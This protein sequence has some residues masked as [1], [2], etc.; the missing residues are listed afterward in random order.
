MPDFGSPVAAN[1]NVDPNKGLT[2]LSNLM[3]LQQQKQQIQSGA[4]T[5]QRQQAELPG[6]QAQTQG[7]VQAMQERQLLQKSMMAGKDPDGNPLKTPEGDYDPVALTAFA[8]KYLPLTGQQVVQHTVKTLD[9]RIRLNDA[10]RGVGQNYANDI[11]GKI[12]SFIG[13]NATPKDIGDAIDTYVQQ[14]PNGGQPLAIAAA[15]AKSL[16]QNLG[17]QVP[18]QQR[19]N[20]LLHLAQAFQPAGATA[21]QQAPAVEGVTNEQGRRAYVQTNPQAP[22]GTGP[23]LNAQGKP[24]TVGQGLAP[25]IILD[26]NGQPHYVGGSAQGPNGATGTTPWATRPGV[27]AQ[28]GAAADMSKH[29]EN[30]NLASQNLPLAT[31]LTK[32]IEGLSPNAYVGVGGDKKQFLSGVLNALGIHATGDAQTDTNLLSKAMAQLNMSTP[33]GTDAARVLVEAGQPNTKMDPAAIKE[34][35]GTVLGQVRMNAAERNF[36]QT[37]RYSNGGAGDIQRYQEGRQKFEANADPRIW[38]Y[39]DLLKSNRKAAQAF[40]SRQPDKAELVRKATE[41]MSMGFFR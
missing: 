30:L 18:Q 34:A 39:E 1:I 20:A 31:A 24:A 32:T 21:A 29:F 7:Q 25:G 19:D 38:Q 10:I 37:Q 13:T 11:S 27:E 8:N 6:V 9:D 40:I 4:L 2:T 12:R 41:L 22:G 23:V 3:G 17:P 33:A 14:N 16:L 5:I 35:A 28:S 26:L 15:K 36:L